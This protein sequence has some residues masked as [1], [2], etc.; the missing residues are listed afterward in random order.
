M[1]LYCLL[2]TDDH[3]YLI[4]KLDIFTGLA[5]TSVLVFPPARV[6]SPALERGI[7]DGRIYFFRN[8]HIKFSSNLT[9]IFLISE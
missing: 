7:L 9:G 5:T 2:I 3:D 1:L 8:N 4:S 6:E